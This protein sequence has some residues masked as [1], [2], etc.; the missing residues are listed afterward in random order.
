MGRGGGGGGLYILEY[1]KFIAPNGTYVPKHK[2][3]SIEI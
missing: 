2:F 3:E 1:F